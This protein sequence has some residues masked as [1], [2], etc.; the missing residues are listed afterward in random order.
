MPDYCFLNTILPHLH[1]LN[2]GDLL[3]LDGLSWVLCPLRSTAH[4]VCGRYDDSEMN[5][6]IVQLMK[7]KDMPVDFRHSHVSPVSAVSDEQVVGRMESCKNG[8][9]T[10]DNRLTLESNTPPLLFRKLLNSR[11]NMLHR[12]FVELVLTFSFIC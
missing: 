5:S 7:T 6:V 1:V 2:L 10:A 8:G 4:E 9:T 11:L 12:S 3:G